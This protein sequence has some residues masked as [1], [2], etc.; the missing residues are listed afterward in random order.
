MRLLIVAASAVALLAGAARAEVTDRSAAGFEVTEAA[1]I[2]AP[3]AKVWKALMQP[4]R[5]WSS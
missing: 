2:A 3:R 4:G 5:W 1:T